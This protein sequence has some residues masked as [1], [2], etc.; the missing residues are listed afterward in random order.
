MI[1]EK[2]VDEESK[3]IYEARLEY[4]KTEDYISF[5]GKIKKLDKKWIILDP[6]FRQVQESYRSKKDIII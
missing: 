2:L 4:Y 3:K 6:C 5:W 1:K